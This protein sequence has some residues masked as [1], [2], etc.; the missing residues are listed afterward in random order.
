MCNCVQNGAT[1]NQPVD[2]IRKRFEA[3]FGK[4]EIARKLALLTGANR[5]TVFRWFDKGFP[6]MAI[7]TLELLERCPPDEW[8]ERAKAAKLLK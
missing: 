2:E 7:L 6:E 3:L 4:K 8:P 1:L 5:A